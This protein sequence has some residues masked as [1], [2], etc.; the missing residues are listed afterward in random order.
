MNLWSIAVKSVKQRALAS[1]LTSLSVALGVMLMVVVLVANGM[2]ERM[3][4]QTATGYDLILG[5]KGSQLELVL[6]S[7]YRIG[8]AGEPLPYRFYRELTSETG[9]RI[10]RAIP[11]TM[12]DVTRQGAF[13][14]VG[15]T[16]DYF[17]LPYM[18]EADGTPRKFQFRTR[19]WTANTP[20]RA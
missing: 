14:I 7:I 1:A 15:T 10:D 4:V 20:A 8:V 2:A 3:F 17:V 18:H 5:P 11:I 12:G 9:N 19:A 16:P 13:P 6:T